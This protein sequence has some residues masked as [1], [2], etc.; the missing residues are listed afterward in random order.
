MTEKEERPAMPEQ[1]RGDVSMRGQG[2]DNGYS[3]SNQILTE[4]FESEELIRLIADKKAYLPK[5]KNDYARKKL[6]AEIIL[7]ENRIL[8]IAQR[9]TTLF[10][11]ESTR[12]FERSLSRVVKE[13]FDAMLLFLPITEDVGETCM[14]GVINPKS[15]MFGINPIENIEVA[16]ESLGICRR[17]IEPL[18]IEL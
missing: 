8:P 12:Y 5:V 18:N 6:Q 4:S 2:K 13:G 17:K 10:Y 9:E 1:K 14:V 7:L 15:Q 3:S 11:G 16:I